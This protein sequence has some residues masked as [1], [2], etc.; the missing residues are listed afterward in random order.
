MRSNT[1]KTVLKTIRITEELD[2][3]L[4]KDA[5]AKRMNVN[6][7]ISSIL[8]KYAEWDRFSERFGIVSLRQDTMKSLM[9]SVE[10]E[11]LAKLAKQIGGRI[12]KE[13]ILF[14]FK[15]ITVETYLEYLARLCRYSG[16]GQYE[17]ETDGRDYIITILHNMGSKWSMYLGTGIEAGMKNTI[18]SVP[19]LETTETSIVIRFQMP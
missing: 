16:Y 13:L 9:E 18:G 10:D 19:R 7:L 1:K 6:T 4:H 8:T 2:E 17:V 11:K 12:P 3:I 5:E 14:L 15:K